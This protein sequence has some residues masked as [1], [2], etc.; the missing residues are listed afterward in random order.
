MQSRLILRVLGSGSYALGSVY[1]FN[2]TGFSGSYIADKNIKTL[3][4]LIMLV[5]NSVVEEDGFIQRR[6]NK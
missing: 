4:Y 2:H 5:T 6:I 1:D 3:R